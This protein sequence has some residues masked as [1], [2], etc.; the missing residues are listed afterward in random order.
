[1]KDTGVLQAQQNDLDFENTNF[2]R[3]V[4]IYI[5]HIL[6]SHKRVSNPDI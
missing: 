5:P 4:D 3:L 6:N 1:M 2:K